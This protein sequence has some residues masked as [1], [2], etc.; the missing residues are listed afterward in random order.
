MFLLRYACGAALALGTGNIPVLRIA[1]GA[2]AWECTIVFVY[3]F[4]GVMDIKEDQVNQSRRPIAAGRLSQAVALR[5]AAAA[6]LAA[7][8]AGFALGLSFG[9]LGAVMLVLGYFYSGRPLYLKRGVVT[10]GLTGCLGGLLTYL[11]GRAAVGA[12]LLTS[13]S[14]VFAVVMSLWIGLVGSITKDLPDMAGDAAAGRR[15]AALMFGQARARLAAAG[16][17]LAVGTAF[18]AAALAAGRVLVWPAI[19]LECGAVALAAV[20]VPRWS[21]GSPASRRR[22]YRAFM[23]SQYAAHFALLAV[24]AYNRWA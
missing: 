19:T 8:A 10:G 13:T 23:V 22:P 7:L 6:V 15:T 11:A 17:A 5:V 9:V 12:P 4:N 1:V 20:T 24:L 21:A 16:A 18:L 3:L 2:I 14:V